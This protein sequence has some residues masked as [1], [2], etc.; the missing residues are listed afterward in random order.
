[1]LLHL[2]TSTTKKETQCLVDLFRFWRWSLP[3]LDVVLWP[4]YQVAACLEGGVEQERVLFTC[5]LLLLLASAFLHGHY[6]LLILDPRI[7]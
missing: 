2:A 4:R 5:L 7:H 1:M 6:S 3:Q